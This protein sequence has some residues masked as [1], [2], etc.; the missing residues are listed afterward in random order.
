ML[1]K[2]VV[3][4]LLQLA[5]FVAVL[6]ITKSELVFHTSGTALLT[7][8]H[9]KEGGLSYDKNY[10]I[11][12][13]MKFL[14]NIESENGEQ[15]A[16][17]LWPK[18]PL[19]KYLVIVPYQSEELLKQQ[20]FT[21]RLVR[22]IYKCMV[23]EMYIEMFEF[24]K[25]LEDRYPEYKGKYSELPSLILDTSI[26]PLGWEGYFALTQYYWGGFAV[27]FILSA[28]VLAWKIMRS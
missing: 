12:H 27:L 11:N 2:I 4:F 5:F 26:K 22:C 17:L 13:P 21:G 16:T 19:G 28:V 23:G 20:V 9:Q 8:N 25:T 6:L 18:P 7:E 1:K 3:F 15:T 10:E 24:V 14:L